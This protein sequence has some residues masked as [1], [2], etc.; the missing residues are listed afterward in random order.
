MSNSS[1]DSVREELTRRVEAALASSPFASTPVFYPNRPFVQPTNAVWI[2]M[3]V[4]GGLGTQANLGENPVERQIGI[5]QFYVMI[6]ENKGTKQGNDLADFLGKLFSRAQFYTDNNNRVNFK[7]P[8]YNQVD[9]ITKG[10]VTNI[11]KIT[12]RRDENTF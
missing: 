10:F 7:V 12:F 1:L 8:Q 4:L 3:D 11:V 5:L 2:K 6:P 9:T